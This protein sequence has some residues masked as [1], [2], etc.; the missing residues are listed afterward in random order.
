MENLVVGVTGASGSVYAIRL[1]Q[2]L[3][4]LGLAAH[5]TVSKPGLE[6]VKY[7]TGFDR[8]ALEH[9]AVWHEVDNL[10]APIASGSFRS[11]G[12]VVL[13]CSMHTLG[14]IAQG[15]TDSLLLRCADVMLKE[16][17][18]LVLVPREAPL[19]KIHVANMLKVMDAGARI[20]P[21]SPAFYH[22][23]ATIDD[24]VDF[25]VGK[26]LD[27]LGIEHNMFRRWGD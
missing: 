18:P 3:K 15:V 1:L 26:V 17:R 16:G 7:E 8:G 25:V 23:P 19:N 9:L 12:M 21:A 5:L 14:A 13:P 6:V 27:N 4:E 10:F 22:K 11:D 24:L 2:V 20:I